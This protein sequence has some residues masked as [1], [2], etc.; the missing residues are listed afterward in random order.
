M[1]ADDTDTGL[2]ATEAS[3]I[4]QAL[5]MARMSGEFPTKI[6]LDLAKLAKKIA[7]MCKQA[8]GEPPVDLEVHRE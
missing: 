7:R 2:T 4:I 6:Q 8:D 3:L 1:Q 5:S